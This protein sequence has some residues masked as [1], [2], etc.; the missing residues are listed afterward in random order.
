M[1]T[2]EAR[3]RSAREKERRGLEA[4]VAQE[5]DRSL[6]LATGLARA[7]ERLAL[8]QAQRFQ[9]RTKWMFG[10]ENGEVVV[11]GEPEFL[12]QVAEA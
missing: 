7:E 5:Q 3:A 4:R 10:P 1:R 12:T 8:M 6:K 11:S 2:A 9:Y